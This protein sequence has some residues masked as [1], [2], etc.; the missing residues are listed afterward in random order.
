MSMS[1]SQQTALA[2]IPKIT[3]CISLISSLVIAIS[4]FRDPKKRSKVYHRLILGMS[5]AD[6]SSSLWLSLSTWPIPGETNILWAVG[7]T[8]SCTFQGFF[9]QFGISSPVYNVSLSFYYL[10]AVRYSWKE[11]RLRRRA[12]PWFHILPLLWSFGT[13]IAGLFLKIF[14]SANLWCWI[15]P[16]EG[17]NDDVAEV[18]AYRFVLFYGPL[19]VAIAVVTVNL[20][21]IFLYVRSI[22]LQ[23]LRHENRVLAMQER[24]DEFYYDQGWESRPAATAEADVNQRNSQTSSQM[25][26]LQRTRISMFTKRRRKVFYQSLRFALALY[27]TWFPITILRILQSINHPP[28]YVIYLLAAM[29]TPVQG[30]P[31]FI[32]YLYPMIIRA[33]RGNPQLNFLVWIQ[34]AL[35]PAQDE[36]TT[37]S[38]LSSA[39]DLQQGGPTASVATSSVVKPPDHPNPDESTL[40]P[41]P[42]ANSDTMKNDI[43]R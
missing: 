23:S 1:I 12:E 28:V 31:N 42:A 13:A 35:A 14:N 29:N 37:S 26:S 34:K 4:I 39:A 7:N 36:Y 8:I 33:K 43:E 27:W 38:F 5:L 40:N 2:L 21:L 11:E 30:L 41:N 18:N 32:V 3:G 24:A 9:T 17:R 6:I 19:W 10:L 25:L 16:Y 22:T 15:A 20:I